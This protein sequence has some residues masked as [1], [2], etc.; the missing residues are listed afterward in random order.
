MLGRSDRLPT[1]HGIWYGLAGT[2]WYIVWPTGH[3]AWYMAWPGRHDRIY[4]T[5]WEAWRGIW[6]G[7]AGMALFMVLPGGH[8]IVFGMAWEGMAWYMVLN[9]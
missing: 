6:Y 4:G 7:L 9:G 8:G 5:A 1:W 2:T 3:K